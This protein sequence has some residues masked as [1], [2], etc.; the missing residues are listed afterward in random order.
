MRVKFQPGFSI[1]R[2]ALGVLLGAAAL[3]SPA[4]ARDSHWRSFGPGGG[5]IGSLAIDPR[6][7][8]VVYAANFQD[9]YRSR[10]G[11]ETWS[12]FG[13]PPISAVAI[14]PSDGAT[15]YAGGT[16]V[17]RSGDGGRTWQT[18][19]DE[20]GLEVRALAVTAGSRPVVFALGRSATGEG[21]VRRSADDGRTWTTTLISDSLDSL[22]LDPIHPA[23]VF[24]AGRKGVF[25]SFDSG[26]SWSMAL[27][28]QIP[29]VRGVLVALAPSPSILYAVASYFTSLPGFAVYRS[30]DGGQTWTQV[31][32]HE[33]T[34][35]QALVVDPASPLKL[36]LA[37]F[38]GLLASTDGGKIWKPF[39]DGLILRPGTHPAGYSLAIAQGR[40]RTLFAGLYGMGVAHT[41]PGGGRWSLPLQTGLGGVYS[42]LFFNPLRS[43]ELL[44][45]YDDGYRVLRSVDDGETWSSLPYRITSLALSSIA[46][47]TANP[48]RYFAGTGD[49]V[50]KTLNRGAT[51]SRIKEDGAVYG[52]ATAGPGVLL[53]A[54]G[55]GLDRSR[56]GGRTWERVLSC[57]H[58]DFLHQ[59]VVRL[60]TNPSTPA[61]IYAAVSTFSDTHPYGNLVLASTD[62][63]ATWREIPV[64]NPYFFEVAAG[65]SRALYSVDSPDK[66][67]GGLERSEDGGATWQT[68]HANPE[69]NGFASLAIDPRDPDTIYL[70]TRSEILRSRDGGR[71]LEVLDPAFSA[72]LT[73]DRA[74][75]GFLYARSDLDGLFERQVE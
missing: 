38:D 10:D 59:Q 11:G 71:T 33:G 55:C 12:A 50:W 68:V 44:V 24:A 34:F 31:R 60:W 15:I 19:L 47:D 40:R 63:G 14:A 52:L 75:P 61:R 16:K 36:Y 64:P 27:N 66:V 57:E 62:G 23:V 20:A 43:G 72:S 69:E 35:D 74:R 5:N 73:T 46:F 18:M 42:P 45:A 3:A 13:L 6:D 54:G 2:I 30:F 53:A 49:G 37:G 17:V 51:W 58:D 65:D 48:D 39:E 29:G 22:A 21:S 9:L 4:G 25:R 7:A 8:R 41:A 70:S 28:L 67:G 32:F 1:L 26:L 56:N